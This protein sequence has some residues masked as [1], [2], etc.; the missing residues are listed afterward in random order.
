MRTNIKDLE[1]VRD[2]RTHLEV[3]RDRLREL[4][5]ALTGSPQYF[6]SAE[7]LTRTPRKNPDGSVDWEKAFNL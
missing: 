4:L 3:P 7:F 1:Y 2:C 5:D 6:F